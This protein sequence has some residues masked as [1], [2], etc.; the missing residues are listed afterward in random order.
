MLKVYSAHWCPHC[1]DTISFLERN[2]IPFEVIDIE[3]QPED[4]VK[5][6]I[7]VNGGDDWVIPTLEFNGKFREG[8]VFN[9]EELKSDLAAL[10]II[11]KEV[12]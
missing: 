3:S 8:K 5:K 11:R 7:E 12:P 2:Q 4:V 9:E 6:I 10:G 1:R